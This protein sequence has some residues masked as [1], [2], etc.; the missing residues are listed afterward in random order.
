MASRM[1]RRLV[2]RGST[3]K[4][5]VSA[6]RLTSARRTPSIAPTTFSIRLEQEAQC[7]PVKAISRVTGDSFSTTIMV[8]PNSPTRPAISSGWT[9][10]GSQVRS[11]LSAARLTLTASTPAM[12][13]TTFSIRAEQA[14]QCMPWIGNWLW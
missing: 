11:M 10:S 5:P 2:C 3:T 13:L 12:A 14:A 9:S 7:M 1:A 6:A 8:K 4:V